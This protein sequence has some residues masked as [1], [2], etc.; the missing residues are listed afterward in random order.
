[1]CSFLRKDEEE[2]EEEEEEEDKRVTLL[3]TFRFNTNNSPSCPSSQ[4]KKRE[5][6]APKPDVVARGD[7]SEAPHVMSPEIGGKLE[8]AISM[9]PSR[10]NEDY[11]YCHL[12]KIDGV[13][14]G[15]FLLFDSHC[16]K[17]AGARCSRLFLTR[18]NDIFWS[19]VENRQYSRDKANAPVS[20]TTGFSAFL[21]EAIE[22]ACVELD[23][24]IKENTISGTTMCVCFVKFGE[25]RVFLKFANLGDSRAMVKN[26]K[27]EVVFA[28]KDHKPN[29]LEEQ[30][31][32]RGHYDSLHGSESYARFQNLEHVM[33][34]PSGSRGGSS[35]GTSRDVSTRGGK[36]KQAIRVEQGN[37]SDD[38]DDDD[39][40][41]DSSLQEDHSL[42]DNIPANVNVILASKLSQLAANNQ[43]DDV[44]NTTRD[45][46]ADGDENAKN[47]NTYQVADKRISFIG[48]FVSDDPSGSKLSDVRLF[49]PSGA[50]YGM[51]R[52]IGDVNSPRSMIPLPDMTNLS[53]DYDTFAM[54]IIA[55]DG[56]WDTRT[57]EQ[58]ALFSGTNAEKGSKK[59]C[60]LSWDDRAYSGKAMDDISVIAFSLNADTLKNNTAK[61]GCCVIS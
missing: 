41:D 10:K 39:D 18:L 14:D 31:R 49:S 52:S 7:F 33:R 48:E 29:S 24:E 28:T 37:E 16:G 36:R 1:V 22:R 38:D 5:T 2:E 17:E 25:K 27:N 35:R 20:E 59:L 61:D 50:S 42:M 60:M 55:S 19:M 58:A 11:A 46:A 15:C 56:L 34:S 4:K 43:D 8:Y 53:F 47:P 51:S 6:M 21:D 30:D 40:D 3:S 44:R 13:C 45:E 12:A 32:I 23:E 9:I 26:A 57:N 54:V